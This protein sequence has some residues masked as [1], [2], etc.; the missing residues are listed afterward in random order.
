MIT[1]H[2][3][4]IKW[5]GGECPVPSDTIVKVKLRC[6]RFGAE[7]YAIYFMWHHD[8]EIDGNDIIEYRT[9]TEQP[10]LDA[11]EKLLSDNGYTVVPPA[12]PPTFEDLT[13][14]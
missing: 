7:R 5:N 12:K 6:G 14:T 10:D 4:W 9:I 13:R 3:P 11:A 8:A 2:K 1:A